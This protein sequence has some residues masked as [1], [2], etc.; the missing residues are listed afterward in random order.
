MFIWKLTVAVLVNCGFCGVPC[1]FGRKVRS[2]P[3]EDILRE[4]KHFLK[5][6]ARK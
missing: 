5:K 4:V 3:L 1:F 6:G 2:R